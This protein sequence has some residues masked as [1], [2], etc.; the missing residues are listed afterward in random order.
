MVLSEDGVSVVV[1]AV[2]VPLKARRR[3][4]RSFMVS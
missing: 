4:R 3:E 1:W 2:M